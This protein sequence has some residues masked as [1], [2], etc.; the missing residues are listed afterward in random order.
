MNGEGVH[1]SVV[2]MQP[3]RDSLRTGWQDDGYGLLEEDEERYAAGP[4]LGRLTM[5]VLIDDEVVDVVRKPVQGTGYECAA[6]ELGRGQLPKPAYQPPPPQPPRHERE[7]AWLARLVGGVTQLAELHGEPLP[8]EPLDLD[9]VPAQL[10][11]RVRVIGDRADDVAERLFGAE[12][13]TACRRLLVRAVAAEPGLLRDRA[14]DET[15]PAAV[16][17]AVAKANDLV[18]SG[19][20]MPVSAIHSLC[21]LKS[22][23]S[24]RGR[25]FAH[26]VAGPGDPGFDPW[27]YPSSSQVLELGAADLLTSRFRGHLIRRRDLAEAERRAAAQTDS[28]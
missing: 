5:V 2:P 15:A 13:R 22:T 11:E 3:W 7:L 27:R 16:L 14:R 12:V 9:G 21:G 25:A 10:R 17:W 19:R 26:A 1:R 23:P 28:A 8:D 20:Q 4:D 6:L 24:E 18:G